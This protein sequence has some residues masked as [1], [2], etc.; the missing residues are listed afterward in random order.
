M[1]LGLTFLLVI[2]MT[3]CVATSRADSDI[4]RSAADVEA[5]FRNPSTTGAVF[6]IQGVIQSKFP[7]MSDSSFAIKD[8]HGE[9]LLFGENKFKSVNAG[10]EGIFSG[11]ARTIR[12]NEPILFLTNM[13]RTGTCPIDNP[14]QLALCDIDERRHHLC[15]IVTTGIVVEA[16][17]DEIDPSYTHLILQDDLCTLSVF[18]KDDLFPRSRQL[19][20]CSVRIRGLY[21][22][23]LP[24]GRRYGN[25]MLIPNKIEVITPSPEPFDAPRLVTSFY[26]TPKELA[27][28]GRRTVTGRVLACW[29]ES[30]FLLR[31]SDDY[32]IG[33]NTSGSESRPPLGATV[34]ASGYP[35]TDL[36]HLFLT[37]ALF[38]IDNMSET[39]PHEESTISSL[40][41]ILLI[42]N[43]QRVFANTVYGKTASLTGILRSVQAPES[44]ERRAFVEVDGVLIPVDF[45]VVPN[46]FRGMEIGYK[47]QVTGCC[48]LQVESRTPTHAYPPL[49]D[50][51]LVLRQPSD[52]VIIARTPWWTVGKLLV[53]IGIL[54]VGLSALQLRNRILKRLGRLKLAERTRLAVELHDSLSQS[55][56]GL[57]C[58][59]AA[60]NDAVR[61]EPAAVEGKLATADRMLRSCRTELRQCLFD[62]RGDTLN[63]SNFGNAVRRTIEHLTPFA[64]VTMRINVPRTRLD[65]SIAHAALSIIRELVTNAIRHATAD[66][67]RIAGTVDNDLL[68]FSVR[69][70]GCGFDPSR[71]KGVA[72]GHFGLNGIRERI[73]SLRGS[74]DLRSTPGKGTRAVIT[75]PLSPA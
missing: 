11:V 59:I 37:R 46:A 57:A 72:D 70:D 4:L 26:Q 5:F 27:L 67:V 32:L 53:V 45:S 52:V 3:F 42:Q 41:D 22:R 33:V 30:W 75:L 54:L 14:I 10:D 50:F 23:T 12:G 35:G 58:Q 47:I 29:C 38:R 65:D 51:T 49:K 13:L 20:G 64:D 31:T 17:Q 39:V 21:A 69:D 6:S 7:F 60:A 62:L 25:P 34:T 63:D 40:N 71:C 43:G 9:R 1:R 73:K 16:R 8:K 44:P 74:F 2:E 15:E 66:S 18:A 55:L 36:Y 19:I 24:T 68:R 56:A 28:S 61:D 48:I